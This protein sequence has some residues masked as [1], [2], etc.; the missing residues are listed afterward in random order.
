MRFTPHFTAILVLAATAAWA[1]PAR[2]SETL[3][4]SDAKTHG[5]AAKEAAGL[6]IGPKDSAKTITL[7]IGKSLPVRLPAQPGTGYS[8]KVLPADAAILETVGE[9]AAE[10]KG[11][12]K[13]GGQETQ[14]F[15]FL[16][17]GAGTVALTFQY[18]RGWEKDSK[19]AQTKTFHIVVR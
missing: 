1:L 8:W 16:A 13:P 17:K 7:E 4:P 9:P 15:H 12:G 6:T 11:K 5:A 3:R 19:P 10:A 18:A 2:S 14:V